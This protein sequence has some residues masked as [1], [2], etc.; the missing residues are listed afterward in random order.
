MAKFFL[1]IFTCIFITYVDNVE[2]E[3][4]EIEVQRELNPTFD[5]KI[6]QEKNSEIDHFD[7][8]NKTVSKSFGLI[9]LKY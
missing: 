1:K 8:K 9:I 3:D 7:D 6:F 4:K 5:D 2:N